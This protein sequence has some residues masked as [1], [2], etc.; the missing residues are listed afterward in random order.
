MKIVTVGLFNM[1]VTQISSR[2]PTNSVKGSLVGV[3]PL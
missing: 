3:F 2:Q 1:S